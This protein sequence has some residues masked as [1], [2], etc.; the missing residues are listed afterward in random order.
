MRLHPASDLHGPPPT[1]SPVTAPRRPLRLPARRQPTR[2]ALE[3]TLATLEAL[4]AF[5]LPLRNGATAA[6]PGIPQRRRDPAA[7][8]ALPRR[9]TYRFAT[10]ELPARGVKT[11]FIGD[12]TA[13]TDEDFADNVTSWCSGEPLQ[14]AASRE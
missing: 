14:P 3:T 1:P 2:A 13:L 11:R 9:G 7:G 6:A 4:S 8:N 10:I 12:L 5:A